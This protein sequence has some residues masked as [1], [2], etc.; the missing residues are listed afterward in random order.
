MEFWMIVD[1]SD[2][3]DPI[4]GYGDILI[5]EEKRPSVAY[6]QEGMAA[7]ALLEKCREDPDGKYVLMKSEGIGVAMEG[8]RNMLYR[9]ENM[10]YYTG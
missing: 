9:I 4:I 7:E 5:T 6:Y 3:L 10:E 2:P 8:S 1:I